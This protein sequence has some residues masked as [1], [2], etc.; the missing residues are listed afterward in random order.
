M[1]IGDVGQQ[2]IG[3]F[4]VTHVVVSS[5]LVDVVVTG[6]DEIANLRVLHEVGGNVVGDQIVHIV[7]VVG[8][9]LKVVFAHGAFSLGRLVVV[10]GEG[11]HC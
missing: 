8:E 9:V 10:I 11:K 7:I 6:L 4:I 2:I 3:V 5:V 1:N